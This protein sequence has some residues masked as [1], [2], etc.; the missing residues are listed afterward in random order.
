MPLTDRVRDELPAPLVCVSSISELI[1]L[2]RG[3]PAAERLRRLAAALPDTDTRTLIV[4][5]HT[6]DDPLLSWAIHLALDRRDVP[7]A[8]RWPANESDEQ[9]LYITW[10]ADLYWLCRRNPAHRTRFRT[11]QAL[12]HHAPGSPEWHARTYRHFL[13]VQPR[14][15][16]AHWCSKG[17]AITPQHRAMLMTMP[18]NA[19]RADR[20]GL[21]PERFAET[22]RLLV[23]SAVQRP[24]KSGQRTPHEIAGRRAAMWRTYILACRNYT[25]ASEQWRRITGEKLTRQAF[26]KQVNATA[27]V[28]RR[29]AL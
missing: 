25:V 3:T 7:P 16:V 2:R 1:A 6:T 22:H 14:Y 21:E 5:L 28:L 20:R 19:M 17:L 4:R 23:E 9:A 29:A 26:A 12:F 27:E 10:I 18:T 13:F 24:D 8:F 11:W 15:S